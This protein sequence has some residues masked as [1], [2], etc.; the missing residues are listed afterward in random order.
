MN[1]NTV[2]QQNYNDIL[3]RKVIIIFF[4]R[5]WTSLLTKIDQIDQFRPMNVQ[6]RS[7]SAIFL[8]FLFKKKLIF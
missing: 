6:N 4:G 1:Q 7:K 5:K 2:K 3:L 8:N